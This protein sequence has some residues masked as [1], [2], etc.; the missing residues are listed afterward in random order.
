MSDFDPAIRNAAWWATD[1]RRAVNGGLVDV[2]LEKQGKTERPDLSEV[3]EV[4]MGLRMQPVIGRMFED[5]TGIGVREL[6]IAGTHKTE[7]WLR[8]HTDFETADGGLLEVKNY[9]A[10]MIT[11]YSEPDAP[12]RLPATD[13]MQCVHE[14]VVFDKPHVW[15][16]VLF[17]GQRFRYWKIEVTQE[18]RDDFIPMAAEW[19]GYVH[20]DRMPTPE[21]PEQ[22][23]LI[24]PVSN[25][26]AITANQQVEQA[27]MALRMIKGQIKALEEQE[28]GITASLQA[29][30]GE[31]DEII[32]VTGS[33]LVTWR[34]AKASTKFDAKAFESAMPDLYKQFK[35]E[36]PG[37]RRFLIKGEK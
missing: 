25:P 1:T 30:M 7:K 5:Q 3:E 10:A 4:Q 31:A 24:Y 33:T 8:A 28:S 18:M 35:R 15:F 29:F 13:L 16:A 20:S 14:A 17:G 26:R 36:M 32:D 27:C 37:S 22:A 21:T 12:L 34:S 9:N 19:W 6:D 2:I 11:K 23:R